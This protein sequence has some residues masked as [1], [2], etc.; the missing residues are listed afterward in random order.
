M[1]AGGASFYNRRRMNFVGIESNETQR[2]M[3]G[4]MPCWGGFLL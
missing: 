2:L 4:E 1:T 3:V